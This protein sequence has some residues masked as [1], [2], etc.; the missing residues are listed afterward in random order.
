MVTVL[1]LLL[2]AALLSSGRVAAQ[3]APHLPQDEGRHAA[4]FES[5]VVLA[6][7]SA[8]DGTPYDLWVAFFTGKVSIAPVSGV[9]AVI[10]DGADG[11]YRTYQRIS[12]PLRDRVSHS[13]EALRER[14]GSSLLTRSPA[15]DYELS[16]SLDGLRLGLTLR[17]DKPV[18]ELGEIAV[19]RGRRQRYF[20]TPRGTVTAR[21]EENGEPLAL[22]GLGVFQHLW[23]DPPREEG[24]AE[25]FALH[26]DDG[27]DVLAMLNRSFPE[28]NS[29]A[30]ADP[31]S[32]TRVVREF[33]AAADTAGG[34]SGQLLP[35]R[36]RFSAVASGVELRVIPRDEGQR[37]E[38]AGIPF[39]IVRADVEGRL[40]GREVR[41]QGYAYIRSGDR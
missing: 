1:A 24:A 22:Q 31:R 21:L 28:N 40:G 3:A 14:Y 2:A 38:F 29:L 9:Y 15:G 35:T 36:W 34:R 17:P 32:A 20:A 12:L 4:P 7:L 8:P 41:G 30:V 13:R 10:A 37:V 19:G 27:S 26:L 6:H 33:S 39:R 16:L 23:G 5:W 18:I 25:I 11:T